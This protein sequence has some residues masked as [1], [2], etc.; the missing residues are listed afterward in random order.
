MNEVSG[1]ES[2]G[3]SISRLSTN[4][5]NDQDIAGNISHFL[6]FRRLR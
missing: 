5:Y 1:E 3:F 2:T 6:Y 4:D